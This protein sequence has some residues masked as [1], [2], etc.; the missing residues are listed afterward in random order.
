MKIKKKIFS[1]EPSVFHVFV[2]F[3]MRVNLIGQKELIHTSSIKKKVCYD[4]LLAQVVQN[5]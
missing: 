4:E 3:L 5:T 1:Q 2:S